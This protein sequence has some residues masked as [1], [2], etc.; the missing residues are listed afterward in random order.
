MKI[1][2]NENKKQ[3][4]L[5]KKDGKIIS[6]YPYKSSLNKDFTL[7]NLKKDI[8]NFNEYLQQQEE[9]DNIKDLLPIL[10]SFDFI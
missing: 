7:E 9:F 4:E 10:N 3:L 2:I 5:V 1:L 6:T 8:N